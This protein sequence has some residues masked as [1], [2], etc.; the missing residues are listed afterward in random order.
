[1]A[2]LLGMD[3]PGTMNMPPAVWNPRKFPV[4]AAVERRPS[5]GP[6]SVSLLNSQSFLK[7]HFSHDPLGVGTLIL[8][9]NDLDPKT[10]AFVEIR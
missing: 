5:S 6:S 10:F 1:M 8:D 4:I 2:M 7:T 3:D 9:L